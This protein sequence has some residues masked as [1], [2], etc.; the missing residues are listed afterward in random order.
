MLGGRTTE[1]R[2]QTPQ[3]VL[4]LGHQ[5]VDRLHLIPLQVRIDAMLKQRLSVGIEAADDIIADLDQALEN[6]EA[7]T[8]P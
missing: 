2:E 4:D 7:C 1:H 8:L 5:D 6:S 3:H